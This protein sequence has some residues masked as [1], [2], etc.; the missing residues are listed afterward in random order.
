MSKQKKQR[1]PRQR[2]LR[3]LWIAVCL[4]VLVPLTFLGFIFY[5]AHHPN[6]NNTNPTKNSGSHRSII[7]RVENPHNSPNGKKAKNVALKSVTREFATN[8]VKR[9]IPL[10]FD[11]ISKTQALPGATLQFGNLDRKQYKQI[12]TTFQNGSA[13]QNFN[14]VIN[15]SSPTGELQWGDAGTKGVS[16]ETTPKPG[17]TYTI[18]NVNINL[19]RQDRRNFY[20]AVALQ[21]H[22]ANFPSRTINLEMT[23]SRVGGVIINTRR[24]GKIVINN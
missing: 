18:D 12:Y 9:G 16:N 10:A 23:V 14:D 2:N 19:S 11:V 15:Y 6:S 21:Y 5:Q 22:A 7:A 24:V 4:I 13:L 1:T 3:G 8:N 17:D 20:Y